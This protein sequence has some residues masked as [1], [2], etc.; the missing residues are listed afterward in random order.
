MKKILLIIGISINLVAAYNTDFLVLGQGSRGTGMGGAFS[1]IADDGFA[2]YW[3]PAGTGLISHTSF[4][5]A[6]NSYFG[7]FRDFV[8]V[9]S[10]PIDEH[11][12]GAVSVLYYTTSPIEMYPESDTIN[13]GNPI[14]YFN[15]NDVL[16]IGN[17]AYKKDNFSFGGNISMQ[18]QEMLGYIGFGMQIDFGAIYQGFVNVGASCFG[19]LKNNIKWSEQNNYRE[20]QETNFKVGISKRIILGND[21]ILPSFDIL[22]SY[23]FYPQIGLEYNLK[24]IFQLRCGYNNLLSYT[25]G[26]GF[27][28]WKMKIDYSLA[29]SDAGPIN[30]I[31][32]I[33]I[34]R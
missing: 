11:F 16:V 3:N 18:R 13:E 20:P 32:L 7:F 23:K 4:V 21:E 2:P 5:I 9:F 12:A 30:R 17:C 14:R 10:H 24:D 25:F 22:Y 1:S 34:K 31:N 29:L 15:Y 26:V 8:F 19:I 33:Y 27:H 28:F 6:N